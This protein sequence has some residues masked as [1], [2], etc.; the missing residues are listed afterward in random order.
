MMRAIGDDL[1][2]SQLVTKGRVDAAARA[3]RGRASRCQERLGAKRATAASR[4]P[5]LA[6]SAGARGAGS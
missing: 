6:R 2:P 5:T 1:L 4:E 3:R